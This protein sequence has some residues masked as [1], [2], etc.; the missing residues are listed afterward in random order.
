MPV[1]VQYAV[2]FSS[3]ELYGFSVSGNTNANP[4]ATIQLNLHCQNFDSGFPIL[5]QNPS[6][7]PIQN[8]LVNV[9]IVDDF[10]WFRQFPALTSNQ[11]GRIQVPWIQP[12]QGMRVM[13][14]VRVPQTGQELFRTAYLDVRGERLTVKQIVD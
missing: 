4:D 12:D 1:G 14:I 13:L 6:G 9:T 11:D 5:I 7:E 3:K 10:P 2:E 8:A